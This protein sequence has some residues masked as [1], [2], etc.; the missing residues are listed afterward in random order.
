MLLPRYMMSSMLRGGGVSA[1]PCGS[2]LGAGV[3]TGGGRASR[4]TMASA[5]SASM[6]GGW[7]GCGDEDRW[8]AGV[9]P[10][11]GLGTLGVDGGWLEQ[12]GE[13]VIPEPVGDAAPEGARQAVSQLQGVLHPLVELLEIRTQGLAGVGPEGVIRDAPALPEGRHQEAPSEGGR[14]GRGQGPP[15]GGV[16]AHILDALHDAL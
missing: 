16:P 1:P 5:R 8:W 2:R 15:G 14:V 7:N 9:S 6:A 3:K 13:C 4:R 11:Y 10:D 12:A